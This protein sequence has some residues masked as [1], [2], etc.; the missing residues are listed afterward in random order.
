M[1]QILTRDDGRAY[2]VIEKIGNG[3]WS[4]AVFD[5]PYRR[6]EEPQ[7]GTVIG[8]TSRTQAGA[9]YWCIRYATREGFF[10]GRMEFAP[11]NDMGRRLFR[12]R[13]ARASAAAQMAG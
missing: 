5:R 7:P 8:G 2:A 9:I 10:E 6:G 1:S 12:S 13:A 11:E 3:G 4:W